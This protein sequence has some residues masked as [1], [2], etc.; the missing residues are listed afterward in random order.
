LLC[1]SGAARVNDRRRSSEL[2]RDKESFRV[3][4][5]NSHSI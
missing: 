3:I 1:M 5:P 2:G 4:A